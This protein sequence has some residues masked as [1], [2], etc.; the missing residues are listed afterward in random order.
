MYEVLVYE[1]YYRVG[2]FRRQTFRSEKA[3]RTFMAGCSAK[4]VCPQLTAPAEAV[5]EAA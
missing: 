2:F 5:Q 4:T 1:P 3:A